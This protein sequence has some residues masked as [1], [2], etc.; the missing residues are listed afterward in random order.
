MTAR[1][2]N[3]FDGN[4]FIAFMISAPLMYVAD[5]LF[6]VARLRGWTKEWFIQWLFRRGK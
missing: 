3:L 2:T 5:W 1:K 6:A 4:D